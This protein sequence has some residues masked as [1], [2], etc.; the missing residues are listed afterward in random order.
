[1]EQNVFCLPSP[2]ILCLS[3]SLPA[4]YFQSCSATTYGT[5]KFAG[6]WALCCNLTALI[7]GL[8]S[9]LVAILPLVLLLSLAAAGYAGLQA[10][11][12]WLEGSVID[13]DNEDYYNDNSNTATDYGYLG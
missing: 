13:Y 3:L 11:G 4:L 6:K 2:T 9:F 1:M 5:S 8:V 10:L 7:Y 12:D